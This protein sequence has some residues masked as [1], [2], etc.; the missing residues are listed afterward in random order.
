[1][2]PPAF[3]GPRPAPKGTTT[4]AKGA[5]EPQ[6]PTSPEGTTTRPKGTAGRPQAMTPGG[7]PAPG[8]VRPPGTAPGHAPGHT[9]PGRPPG[10]PRPPLTGAPSVGAWPPAPE[11]NAPSGTLPALPSSPATDAPPGAAPGEVPLPPLPSSSAFVPSVAPSP[12]R[13]VLPPY[14]AEEGAEITTPMRRA[15]GERPWVAVP[16][17]ALAAQVAMLWLLVCLGL[18]RH[19]RTTRRPGALDDLG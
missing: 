3:G 17:A 2:R 5:T 8:T 14:L 9:T 10:M 19:R 1:M 15:S 18:W 12:S 11:A 6:G 7:P 13:T 4:K 16:A